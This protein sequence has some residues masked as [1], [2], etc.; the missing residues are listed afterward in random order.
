MNYPLRV[1]SAHSAYSVVS[2]LLEF[3]EFF[4]QP[5]RAVR[6]LCGSIRQP[7]ILQKNKSSHPDR[8][9]NLISRVATHVAF[10]ANFNRCTGRNPLLIR[11]Q[12]LPGGTSQSDVTA[13]TNRRFSEHLTFGFL[14]IMHFMKFVVFDYN[15]Y[16]PASQVS[17][18]LILHLTYVNLCQPDIN[19]GI[20]KSAAAGAIG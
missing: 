19:F 3:L 18:M 13:R 8:D 5:H 17:F 14:F 7:L 10:S 12:T 4:M 9:E 20:I 2:V 11:H 1:P 15:V 16:P 6:V